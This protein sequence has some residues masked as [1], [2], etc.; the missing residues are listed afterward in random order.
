VSATT[1]SITVISSASSVNVVTGVSV[2]TSS[3]VTGVS[4]AYSPLANTPIEVI[5]IW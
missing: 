2:S 3:F 1:K 5:L 4:F